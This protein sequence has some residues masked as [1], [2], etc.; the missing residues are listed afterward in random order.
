MTLAHIDI[1]GTSRRFD[2]P[3]AEVRQSPSVL[4]MMF[5]WISEVPP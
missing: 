3:P 1:I 5:F 2:N 4:A